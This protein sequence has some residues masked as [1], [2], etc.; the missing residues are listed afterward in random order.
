[1]AV[2]PVALVVSA[3]QPECHFYFARR[4]SFLS[5]ADTLTMPP[6]YLAGRYQQVMSERGLIES[7]F[8]HIWVVF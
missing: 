1:L 6:A 8:S 2:M 4:V 5:C 3:G 7:M